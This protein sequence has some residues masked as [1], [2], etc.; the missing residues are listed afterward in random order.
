MKAFWTFMAGESC[1]EH[2]IYFWFGPCHQILGG[3]SAWELLERKTPFSPEI[4]ENHCKHAPV[5]PWDQRHGKRNVWRGVLPRLEKVWH[6]SGI[7]W[8]K[9]MEEEPSTEIPIELVG[10]T[11]DQSGIGCPDW[12][13]S[14]WGKVSPNFG[15]V[16]DAKH[17]LSHGMSDNR[18]AFHTGQKNW[19]VLW[20]FGTNTCRTPYSQA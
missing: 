5:I 19:H 13:W 1:T 18:R 2:Q 10:T 4:R 9:P 3:R 6:Q 11:V 12:G 7:I 16:Q 17:H 14:A 15:P 20:L 8:E